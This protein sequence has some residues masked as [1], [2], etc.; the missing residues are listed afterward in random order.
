MLG[1]KCKKAQPNVQNKKARTGDVK[2]RIANKT[3]GK[4]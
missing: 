1:T 2:T 3:H 4:D